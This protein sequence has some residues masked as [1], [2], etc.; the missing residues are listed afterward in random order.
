MSLFLVFLLFASHVFAQEYKVTDQVYFDVA[1]DNEYKGRIVIGLFGEITPKTAKNFYTL[2]T[3]GIDGKNYTGSRFHRVIR[4]FMIQGGDI[5]SNNGSGTVSIYG[6]HFDDENFDVDHE[7]P[8]F[9]SMANAGPNTNGCQFF[10]T[11]IGTSWLNGKHTVFGKVVS[12]QNIVHKIELVKTDAHD[13]PKQS[14]VIIN[15]GSIPTPTP[16]Y[17]SAISYNLL[18]IL[19]AGALP[20]IMSFTILAFFQYVISILRKFENVKLHTS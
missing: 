7:G 14:A 12:G 3:E 10:I 4:R 17:V 11:T 15:S 9:V 6:T 5:V 18:E 2:A 19:R 20:L 16:F 1:I 8:G 13:Y